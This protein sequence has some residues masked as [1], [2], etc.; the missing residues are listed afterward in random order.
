MQCITIQH[1]HATDMEQNRMSVGATHCNRTQLVSMALRNQPES[2]ARLAQ[3][4]ERKALN[5][6]VVGSSPTV[7]VFIAHAREKRALSHVWCDI[8]NACSA[9]TIVAKLTNAQTNDVYVNVDESDARCSRC[10]V[11][12][13]ESIG[14]CSYVIRLRYGSRLFY[15]R[16][17]CF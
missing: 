7:G 5:L 1:A 13:C 15:L 6:V 2:R 4:A 12:L 17:R 10:C 9:P 8:R 11:Y 3:S 14:A 16:R